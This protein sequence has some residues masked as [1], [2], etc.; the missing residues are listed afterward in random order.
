[1]EM[2]MPRSDTMSKTF[3]PNLSMTVT[4][5]NVQRTWMPP[6]IMALAQGSIVLPLL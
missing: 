6:S 5:T 1:M 4:V 3:R 2:Q